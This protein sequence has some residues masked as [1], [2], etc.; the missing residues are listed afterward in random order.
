MERVHETKVVPI[1]AAPSATSA[2]REPRR[3][4]R[5]WGWVVGIAAT[6]LV[7]AGLA[8]ENL[9]LRRSLESRGVEL[10]Q[11]TA[12]AERRERQLDAVLEA[13][14]DLYV[15]QMKGADTVTGPGIQFFWN[16][17]QHRAILHAFRLP[18]ARDGRA[19]QLWLIQD[20]K[21]VSAKVFNSDPDGHA[22]VEN[23]QVPTTPNGVTQVLLTEEPA[24]DRRCRRRSRSSAERWRRPSAARH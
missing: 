11:A 3:A 19:Y 5:S 16:A 12:K 15:A 1:S 10:A 4:S 23:I 13:E 18:P 2:S 6:L 20:G 17:K 21:P 7:A 22:L 24:G 9:Q 14:K 8:L